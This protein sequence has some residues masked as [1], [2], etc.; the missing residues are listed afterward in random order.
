MLTENMAPR[1]KTTYF[2][3]CVAYGMSINRNVLKRGKEIK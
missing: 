3:A 1:I 2:A